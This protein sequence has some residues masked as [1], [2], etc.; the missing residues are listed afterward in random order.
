MAAA[1]EAGTR[2]Y[3][4]P[5]GFYRLWLEGAAAGP[6]RG[7]A[8][9]GGGSSGPRSGG[10]GTAEFS[11][12]LSGASAETA[13][14]TLAL[15]AALARLTPHWVELS[16]ELR[17]Q[18]LQG[19]LPT[20]PLDLVTRWYNATNGPLT[21]MIRDL[22]S[23]EAYLES[24]RRALENYAT[25]DTVFRRSAEE[26]FGH[27][28]LATTSDATRIAGM[29][30]S[31]DDKVDRLEDA[32]EDAEDSASGGAGGSAEDLGELRE[33][34]GRVEDKLDRLLAALGSGPDSGPDR[35]AGTSNGGAGGRAQTPARPG[36][37]TR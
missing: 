11:R 21:A 1:N 28:Q 25:L 32:I 4:D 14:R 19:G 24:S 3:L 34:L 23:D 17:R 5:F 20:D 16:E 27:L 13:R 29:L 15:G 30:V 36:G 33:R 31:L 2:A 37:E 8:G 22:L 35:D 26:F 7:G 18:L 9:A 6:G 10:T 12:Q